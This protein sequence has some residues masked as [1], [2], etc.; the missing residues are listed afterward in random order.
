MILATVIDVNELRVVA[1]VFAVPCIF[2]VAFISILLSGK[3]KQGFHRYRF[4]LIVHGMVSLVCC[5]IL[6][7][8]HNDSSSAYRSG[9]LRVRT[10]MDMRHL[11]FAADAYQID[12]I[13]LTNHQNHASILNQLSGENPYKRRY[14][15][16]SSIR[17][18]TAGEM[19][20]RWKHPYILEFEDDRLA[21]IISHGPDGELGTDD[22]LSVDRQ[23]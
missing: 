15:Q 14:I 22:D 8:R 7:K 3:A 21:R 20:D 10:E 1:V 17:T 18:N 12:L 23:E 5:G 4:P 6:L 19:V 2:V 13:E 9:H 11:L 16:E